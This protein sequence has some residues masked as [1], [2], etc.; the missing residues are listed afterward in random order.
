MR[1]TCLLNLGSDPGWMERFLDWWLNHG[2]RH[3]L[4]WFA[5]REPLEQTRKASGAGYLGRMNAC[6]PGV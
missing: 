5:Q 4:Q 2:L 3:D 1:Q 6:I